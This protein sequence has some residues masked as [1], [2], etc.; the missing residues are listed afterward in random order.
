M[1]ASLL[2]LETTS[3]YVSEKNEKPFSS[4]GKYLLLAY[5]VV[6]RHR[7]YASPDPDPT[8][9][10]FHADPDPDPDPTPSFTQS[11]HFFRLFTATPVYTVLSFSPLYYPVG[12]RAFSDRSENFSGGLDRN[13]NYI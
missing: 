3:Y 11:G 7:F 2:G 8:F 12:H 13:K 9:H 10:Y 5:T 6:D 4:F 1:F